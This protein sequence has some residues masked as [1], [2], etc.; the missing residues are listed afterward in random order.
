MKKFPEIKSIQ[1]ERISPNW[2]VKVGKFRTK[3]EA[4]RNSR[5]QYILSILIVLLLKLLS[6]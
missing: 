2:K 4:Q 3:T 6:Q 1:Y 5:E